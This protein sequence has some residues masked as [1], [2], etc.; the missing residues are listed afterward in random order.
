[1]ATGGRMAMPLMMATPMIGGAARAM[2]VNDRAVAGAETGLGIAGMGLMT[3]NPYAAGAGLVIGGAIAL[4]EGIEGFK[5]KAEEFKKSAEAA[6]ET[7]TKFGNASQLF[8][9]SI[10]KYNQAIADPSA[11]PERIQ[12]SQK[13]LFDAIMEVPDEF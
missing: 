10:E 2:G 7:L 3:G 5:S 9:S 12:A 13:E 8:L 4:T 1:M 11:S 6:G